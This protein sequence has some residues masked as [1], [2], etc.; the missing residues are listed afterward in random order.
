MLVASNLTFASASLS[1]KLVDWID[2]QV[3]AVTFFGGVTK[4]I[5]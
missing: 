3:R 1:Q 4:A 5:V 2:G